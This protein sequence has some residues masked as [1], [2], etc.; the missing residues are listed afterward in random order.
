ML[1]STPC[2]VCLCACVWGVFIT[3]R[4]NDGRPPNR[5]CHRRRGLPRL[6]R[7]RAPA[8]GSAHGDVVCAALRAR[9]GACP[10]LPQAG[11]RVR[12]T[13]RGDAAAPK[14]AHLTAMPAFGTGQ[15][16]LV[17][18]D[19]LSDD[20]WAAAMVGVT[21]VAH[22]ASPAPSSEPKHESELIEP[23][24]QG[25]RVCASPTLPRA[26]SVPLSGAVCVPPFGGVIPSPALAPHLPERCAHGCGGRD[27]PRAPCCGGGPNGSPRRAHKLQFC[28]V[29]GPQRPTR[30][31]EELPKLRV[32]PLS[33]TVTPLDGWRAVRQA[34]H[35]SPRVTGVCP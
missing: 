19:L 18:A 17:H 11:H 8:S 7:H 25:A 21:W 23:A 20:G 5:A 9:H 30:W 2:C 32:R 26:L 22:V 15:L 3:G 35:L 33:V 34:T 6:P 28:G 10:R 12:G 13:I 1:R 4:T 16:E 27:S 14:H 24:V 31:R 29:S